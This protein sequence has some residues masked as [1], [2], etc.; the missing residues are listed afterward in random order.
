MLLKQELKKMSYKAMADC[1]FDISTQIPTSQEVIQHYL[2]HISIIENQTSLRELTNNYQNQVTLLSQT[3]KNLKENLKNVDIYQ[4]LGLI[5]NFLQGTQD[6]DDIQENVKSDY[7]RNI[8]GKI[9]NLLSETN[10]KDL[11]KEVTI[12]QNQ[13]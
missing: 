9:Q 11:K 6:F 1:L 8:L 3:S 4:D 7:L 5:E 10:K 13:N 12:L 2:P